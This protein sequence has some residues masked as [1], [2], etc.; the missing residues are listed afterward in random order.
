MWL[1]L[2]TFFSL[3]LYG[4]NEKL[5]ANKM[6]SPESK[7]C[8]LKPMSHQYKMKRTWIMINRGTAKL[9][10]DNKGNDLGEI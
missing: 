1:P 10:T 2:I 8:F 4:K 3:N 7:N 5:I 6:Q 9:K